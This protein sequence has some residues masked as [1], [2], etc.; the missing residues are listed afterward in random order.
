M[1]QTKIMIKKCSI[2]LLLFLLSAGQALRADEGMWIPMLLK[3]YNIE[4]MRKK[5]FKLTAE[6]IYSINKT[7]M[8]DAVMIFGG[9][10]TG[11]LI[12][13]RGLLITNHHCGFSSIQTHSSLENDYLTDGFWAMT[14]GQE[15]KNIGLT[16][17]FLVRMED[18]TAKVLEGITDQTPEE[19][20]IEIIKQKI[21]ALKEAAVKGTKYKAVLK[22]FF[23]GNAYYLFVEEVFSD[24]RLVGAP[25]SAIGKFGGDTDNWMWPRHTGDFSLFRIYA[26]KDNK[27][28]E[29]S[30]DNVPYQPKRH[31]PISLKG[32]KKGDFTMVFGYPGRTQENLTSYAVKMITEVENPHQIKIR[33]NKINIMSADMEASKKVRI[34]Y[35]SKYARV[36]N[37]WKNGLAK[38][39]V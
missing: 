5:G 1:Q 30:E 22:P 25:P 18:V 34:Q 4:D 26:D 38:T 31:F 19:E 14:D 12:S 15:L 3:K 10:C 27:P 36:S 6:D 35:A 29:Y 9:G 24:I 20:R 11:E 7:S 13:N 16:V 2:F 33:E 17:T 32:V 23:Y 28:A 39:V 8:K 21:K 37:Y